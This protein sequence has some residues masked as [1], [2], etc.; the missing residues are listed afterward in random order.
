VSLVLGK[1]SLHACGN[2]RP[3]FNPEILKSPRGLAWWWQEV[4]EIG[5]NPGDK[6]FKNTL[7][8]QVTIYGF[9]RVVAEILDIVTSETWGEDKPKVDRGGRGEDTYQPPPQVLCVVMAYFL[10]ECFR[11]SSSV[12]G[13]NPYALNT[14]DRKATQHYF[15]TATLYR[16]V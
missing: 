5:E 9:C 13:R 8:G 3:N 1:D 7:A 15:L 14:V 16:V 2:T 11:I 10:T 4:I 12:R 6:G